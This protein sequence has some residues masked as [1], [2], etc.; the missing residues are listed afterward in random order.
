MGDNEWFSRLNSIIHTKRLNSASNSS[1]S[2]Y[3]TRSFSVAN[4]VAD[5]FDI[6]SQKNPNSQAK[7][8]M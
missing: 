2:A 4:S 8:A 7:E 5:N 3:M 6:L 1:S